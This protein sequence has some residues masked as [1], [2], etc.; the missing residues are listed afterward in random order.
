MSVRTIDIVTCDLC[1]SEISTPRGSKPKGW[2]KIET[3][4]VL[5][6]TFHTRVVCPH[7]VEKIVIT[8]ELDRK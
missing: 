4:G 8:A 5:D 6:R 7:C 2:I 1:E 3:E